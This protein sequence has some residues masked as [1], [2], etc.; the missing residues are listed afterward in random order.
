MRSKTGFFSTLFLLIFLNFFLAIYPQISAAADVEVPSVVGLTKTG[1]S[2]LIHNTG[3]SVGATIQQFDDK[4]PTGIVIDQ[5]PAA[6]T[7]VTAS[8]AVNLTVSLGPAGV[9]TVPDVTGQPE[10][11]AQSILQNAGLTIGTTMRQPDVTMPIGNVIQTTP[12]AGDQVKTGTTVGL[13]VSEGFSG[14]QQCAAPDVTG[15]TVEDA[16]EIL[17]ATCLSGISTITVQR[18]GTVL[19]GRV[20]AQF[21]TAGTMIGYNT[22]VNVIVSAGP[23]PPV[24]IPRVVGLTLPDATTLLESVGLKVGFVSHQTNNTIEADRIISQNPLMT[25]LAPVGWAVNLVISLGPVPEDPSASPQ[26]SVPDVANLTLAAATTKLIEADLRVGVISNQRSPDVLAGQVIRQNPQPETTVPVNSRVNLVISFGPHAYS[27][28][29]GPAYITNYYGNTVSILNP[30]TNQV[31]DNMAT[32]IDN[33]GPSGIAVSPD[34]TRLYVANRPQYGRRTGTLSVIDLTERRVIAIIPVGV[35]PLGVAVNPTG[36]RVFVA[37]EGSFSLSVI[38]TTTNQPFIDLN[39]P[40]L[41][42]NPYPRGVAAHPNPLRPLV[43]VTNRTVNSFSDDATNPYPDQCDGLVSRPPVNIN[44]DQCVGSLSIFDVNL[45]IQVGS[46]AVGWAPEGVAVHPDGM[47]V[48]VA[49]S[50]DRTV[51]VIETVFNRVVGVIALDEFGGAPQPLMPRGI[52]VSPDGN[53]L[54]VT[55]GASNRLFVID[56]TA[57]HSV[58]DIV[59]VGKK[60]YGVAVSPD[61]K[62]VYVANTDDNTV[63]VIEAITDRV[64]AVVPVVSEINANGQWAPWAFGQFVGPLATVATPTFDPPGGNLV[65]SVRISTT[66]SG[67]SISYTTDGSTPTPTHGTVINNGDSISLAG[68]NSLTV[69]LRAIAFKDNWADSE[70]A[71]TIYSSDPTQFSPSGGINLPGSDSADGGGKSPGE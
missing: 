44:P 41:A 65:L 53:R 49:N 51:S 50:G 10:I 61:S 34:G 31:V 5:S 64:I 69:M 57:N 28:L 16:R 15:Q 46:V 13:V 48:Y 18:H 70:V 40:N 14:P 63:S 54:Y 66:T 35:A 56:T 23:Q 71:E 22:T 37:N 4:V 58:V 55:D 19:A 20:A 6:G 29:S 42:A 67:A 24:E 8:T 21:P 2:T 43:Y 33:S 68:S 32:G 17:F 11:V 30:N 3:L 60:P 39:V 26:T 62:R 1:A 47:L 7:K 38:D 59:P 27:L 36:E 9:V 12:V 52:A 25:A 45:K